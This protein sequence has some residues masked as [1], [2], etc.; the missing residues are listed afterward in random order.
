MKIKIVKDFTRFLKTPKDIQFKLN[1]K[2]KL[3]IVSTLLVFELILSFT[4]IFPLLYG[5]DSVLNIKH[6]KLD[7]TDTIFNVVFYWIILIPLIEEL[8]FRYFLR[9]QGLKIKIISKTKWNKFYPFLVY[10]FAVTFGL[11]HLSNYSNDDKL[12][13]I[14]S[15]LIILSQIFGGLVLTYI[16]VRLNFRWA[17]LYHWVWNLLF[18]L[19]IPFIESEFQKPFIEKTADY[20]IVI[21]ER[22]FF[23]KNKPQIMQIDSI[24]SKIQSFYVEQYSLQ[25]ILDTL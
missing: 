22:P 24:K 18:V 10:S 17:V 23:S 7:Y 4:I 20:S 19:I 1:I 21:Q 6:Q 5:I 13:Y 16:R 25:D 15:P 9:Y 14:L 11:T 2:Q 12:F 8:I 3:S